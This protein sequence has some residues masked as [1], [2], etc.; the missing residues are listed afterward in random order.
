[1][2]GNASDFVETAIITF[3]AGGSLEEFELRLALNCGLELGKSKHTI[4]QDKY[5]Y[6]NIVECIPR[7]IEC[8]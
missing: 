7:Y 1:L 8:D 5:I 3:H 6:V 2:S 4:I